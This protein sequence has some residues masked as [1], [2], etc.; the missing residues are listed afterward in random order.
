MTARLIIR[1]LSGHTLV[2]VSAK[3]PIVLHGELESI[4]FRGVSPGQTEELRLKT[5]PGSIQ[6]IEGSLSLAIGE[7]GELLVLLWRVPVGGASEFLGNTEGKTQTVAPA[8]APIFPTSCEIVERGANPVVIYTLYP[9]GTQ[10]PKGQ[11]E[12]QTTTTEYHV[13]APAGESR[14]GGLVGPGEEFKSP[15]SVPARDRLPTIGKAWVEAAGGVPVAVPIAH[16]PGEGAP[17]TQAMPDMETPAQLPAETPPPK[18]ELLPAQ[19]H[20]E[21]PPMPPEVER[22]MARQLQAEGVERGTVPMETEEE[23]PQGLNVEGGVEPL[24]MPSPVAPAPSPVYQHPLEK[25]PA[26]EHRGEVLRPTPRSRVEKIM[27]GPIQPELPPPSSVPHVEKPHEG[28]LSDWPD[29]GG[30]DAFPPAR[31]GTAG[32][33]EE[34]TTQSRKAAHYEQLAAALAAATEQPCKVVP[35]VLGLAMKDALTLMDMRS[36]VAWGPP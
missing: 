11:Q 33:G 16:Q 25:F 26:R 5:T 32:P 23:P 14:G 30:I 27:V 22:N 6:G 31:L 2:P 1:N 24:P 21:L 28:Q 7:T 19:P 8:N 4:H 13:A 35:L 12:A 36:K 34:E 18:V 15:P 17:P 10:L 29:A 20:A 9:P 3:E